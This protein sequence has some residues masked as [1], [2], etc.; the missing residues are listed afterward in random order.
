MEAEQN[1]ITTIRL[2][3][4]V[5]VKDAVPYLLSQRLGTFRRFSKQSRGIALMT[6]GT[7]WWEC[8]GVLTLLAILEIF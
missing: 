7:L 3:N 2:L 1:K 5:T 6:N 4:A 8:H